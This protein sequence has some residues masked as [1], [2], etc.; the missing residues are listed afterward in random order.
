[1]V[2]IDVPNADLSLSPGMFADVT[3]T[4]Q[5]HDDVPTVPSQAVV[6]GHSPYVLVVDAANKVQK[7]TVQL[8]IQGADRIEIQSGAAPGELVITS[9]QT[10]YQQGETVRPLKGGI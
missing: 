7:R 8:G 5:Q 2:E 9:G 4:L 1:M 3:L 10:N 6:Q